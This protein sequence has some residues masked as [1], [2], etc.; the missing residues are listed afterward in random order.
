MAK[1]LFVCEVRK[2]REEKVR[3][4]KTV[5]KLISSDFDPKKF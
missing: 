2:L 3:R 5:I 1:R 4:L